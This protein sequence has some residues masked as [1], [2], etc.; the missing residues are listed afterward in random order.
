MIKSLD[1]DILAGGDEVIDYSEIFLTTKSLISCYM[2]D[3][4]TP[5][6]KNGERSVCDL[7]VPWVWVCP[8][9]RQV[10]QSAVSVD[11]PLINGQY[12]KHRELCLLHRKTA[13]EGSVRKSEEERG[14][15]VRL[16]E[17]LDCNLE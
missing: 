5:T 14:E 11:W 8:L 6:T 15:T 3:W 1:D 12:R 16:L 2:D 13:Q 10:S 9:A 17:W 7:N 4:M